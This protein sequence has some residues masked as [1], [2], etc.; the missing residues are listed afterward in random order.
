MDIVEYARKTEEF[1]P[2][3][4]CLARMLYGLPADLTADCKVTIRAG[5]RNRPAQLSA[6]IYVEQ[7]RDEGRAPKEGR[8]GHKAFVVMGR[9][10]GKD[11]LANLVASYQAT[12]PQFG[13]WGDAAVDPILVVCPSDDLADNCAEKFRKLHTRLN[14]DGKHN[15]TGRMLTDRRGRPVVIH[16]TPHAPE[17]KRIKDRG[18]SGLIVWNDITQFKDPYEAYE[19]PGLGMRQIAFTT[20]D[21]N[22]FVHFAVRENGPLENALLYQ[23]PTW[24]ARPDMNAAFFDI[25]KS[26][27]ERHAP[28]T[29]E[30]ELAE[31][32]FNVEWGAQ[33]YD[34]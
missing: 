11:F 10:S 13:G 29:K 12:V 19:M 5:W 14:L 33:F 34:L 18:T 27:V 17:F 28:H 3:Y 9:K 25:W 1:H 6:P 23:I 26:S 22:G 7:L 30:R 16:T 31:Q 4:E 2:I 24:E 8:G 21:V 15:W 32:K 20:G